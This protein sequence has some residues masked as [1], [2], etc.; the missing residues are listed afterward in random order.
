ME[1]QDEKITRR[2]TV[3]AA[4]SWIEHKKDPTT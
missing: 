2:E 4:K 1:T 3:A